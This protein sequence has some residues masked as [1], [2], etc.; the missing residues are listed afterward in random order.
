M[1]L[2]QEKFDP[3]S[4]YDQLVI[5][6]HQKFCEHNWCDHFHIIGPGFMGGK[7]GFM[8]KFCPKCG[9]VEA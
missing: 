7:Y 2:I 5:A 6:L 3:M 1:M 9:K 8:E 4:F